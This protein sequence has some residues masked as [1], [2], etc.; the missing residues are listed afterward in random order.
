M[1]SVNYYD[2]N[3]ESRERGKKHVFFKIQID[4]DIDACYTVSTEADIPGGWGE[5]EP[6]I[7]LYNYI[8]NFVF[9]CMFC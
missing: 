2:I 4:N 1:N 9:L 6:I 8:A 5:R 7:C 3:F